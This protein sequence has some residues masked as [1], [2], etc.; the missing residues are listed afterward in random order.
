MANVSDTAKPKS[1]IRWRCPICE[2]KLRARA[3][4]AGQKI[5]CPN[6][7][8]PVRVP[9]KTT[10]AR[11]DILQ[12][13][14]EAIG[15]PLHTVPLARVEPSPVSTFVAA[16]GPIAPSA[17]KTMHGVAQEA[18]QATA[19]STVNVAVVDNAQKTRTYTQPLSANSP[20]PSIGSTV[21]TPVEESPE[22]IVISAKT[23]ESVGEKTASKI[24]SPSQRWMFL[25][26]LST[27]E[28]MLLSILGGGSLLTIGIDEV[29]SL[30]ASS[31]LA[32][33]FSRAAIGVAARFAKLILV[34]IFLRIGLVLC[35]RM[36]LRERS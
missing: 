8:R 35:T 19:G 29:F 18:K 10:V 30:F 6:C 14:N 20:T 34:G 31:S 13:T 25:R 22:V 7:D 21:F 32:S 17:A 33:L 12:R 28:S 26:Q 15:I 36:S 11:T 5:V 1:Y 24:Y 16:P 4:V 23:I 3:T 2:K 27:T 9:R